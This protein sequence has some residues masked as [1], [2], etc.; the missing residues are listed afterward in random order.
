[1][2]HIP[3]SRRGQIDNVNLAVMF[4]FW[5]VINVDDR[6]AEKEVGVFLIEVRT[7]FVIWGANA[8]NKVVFVSGRRC[9]YVRGIPESFFGRE[10]DKQFFVLDFISELVH[11]CFGRIK[12]NDEL[13]QVFHTGLNFFVARKEVDIFWGGTICG[14]DRWFLL[15]FFENTR[16]SN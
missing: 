2:T 6:G 4:V 9:F 7:G 15:E 13:T 3:T 10:I 16:K 14:Y 11:F 1:M 5:R 8:N 12:F